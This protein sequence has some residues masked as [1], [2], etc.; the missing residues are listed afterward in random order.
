MKSKN[1][2][3]IKTLISVANTDGNYLQTSWLDI[4][5][6]IS[7]LEFAQ[8]L[9]NS[10]RP[11]GPDPTEAESSFREDITTYQSLSNAQKE[12][13]QEHLQGDTSGGE[14]GLG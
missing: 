12:V 2:E 7:Q 6:S 1:I 3:A 14:P 8:M 13:H 5:K 4:M 11:P 10:Q 9:D